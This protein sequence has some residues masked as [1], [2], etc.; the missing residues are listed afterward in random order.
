MSALKRCLGVRREF[1]IPS[2]KGLSSCRQPPDSRNCDLPMPSVKS[3]GFTGNDGDH[4]ADALEEL[5]N[6]PCTGERCRLRG[7]GL[8]QV[9]RRCIVYLS[10][11]ATFEPAGVRRGVYFESRTG[12]DPARTAGVATDRK[13]YGPCCGS[14]LYVA[15]YTMPLAIAKVLFP[16]HHYPRRIELW[17]EA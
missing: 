17:R 13:I 3:P 4:R 8:R 5:P 16:R 6:A 11:L 2:F 10:S 7:Y 15:L 9:R 12:S 1:T 14:I